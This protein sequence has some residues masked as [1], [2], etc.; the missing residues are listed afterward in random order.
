MGQKRIL[1]ADDE[2]ALVETL[3]D[4][5]ES[6]GFEVLAAYEGVRTIELVNKEK[7]DLIILDLNMP[8]GTGQSVLEAIRNRPSTRS[9]P[10]IVLTGAG[11]PQ[12][13]D[14]LIKLGAQ[15]YIEKPYKADEILDTIYTLLRM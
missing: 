7:P 5:L 9:I 2:E 10:V 8:A 6:R 1:I 14:E 11:L 13:K 3:G 15:A 4:L 12:L